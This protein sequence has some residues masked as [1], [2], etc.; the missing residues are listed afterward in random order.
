MN[1]LIG[2]WGGA[3]KESVSIRGKHLECLGMF[4]MDKHY[5]R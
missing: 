4:S 2:I 5:W 1:I 3:G